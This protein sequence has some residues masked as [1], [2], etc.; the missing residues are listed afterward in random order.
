MERAWLQETLYDDEALRRYCR[1]R[2]IRLAVLFGSWPQ[3]KGPKGSDVEV[4]VLAPR[5]R[6][7]HT[8]QWIFDFQ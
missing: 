8:L 1:E 5:G 7:P 2:R 3:A 6:L 4:A